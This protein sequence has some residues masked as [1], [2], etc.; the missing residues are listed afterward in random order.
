M[1]ETR[2]L[3]HHLER[4][5]T[6][7]A[8]PVVFSFFTDSVRWARWWGPG[9]TIDARVGGRVFIRYPN[10]VEAHGEILTIRPPEYLR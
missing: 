9:S 7:R 10:G 5:V 4:E 2:N 1:D 3:P 6:I 8:Q